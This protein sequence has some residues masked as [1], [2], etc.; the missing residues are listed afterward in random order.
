MEMLIAISSILCNEPILQTSS[1][2]S[3]VFVASAVGEFGKLVGQT[4]I[5]QK[6]Q[7]QLSMVP[8]SIKAV[9]IPGQVL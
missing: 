1:F 9:L 2:C 5:P 3:Y 4:T 8:A 6:A 7:L